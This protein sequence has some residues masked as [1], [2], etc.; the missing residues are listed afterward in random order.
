MKKLINIIIAFCFIS[1]ISGCAG[2]KPLYTTNLKFK[3]NDYS[4]KGDESLGKKIYSKLYN[5]SKKNQ[6]ED[7]NEIKKIAMTITTNKNKIATTKDSAG[8]V[9]GY[10]IIIEGNI[11]I[12]DYVTKSELLNHNFS[13]SSQYS[14]QNQYSE[15]IKLEKQNIENLINKT[16]QNILI[17]MSKE[18][19]SE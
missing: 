3:I 18:M 9:L 8:K 13:H 6:N 15:T 16:Y 7:N 14:V 10:K 1:L 5:L 12:N 2:Y 17:L 19:L 4:L 11:I